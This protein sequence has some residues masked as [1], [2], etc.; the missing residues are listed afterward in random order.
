[1]EFY[2]LN[3]VKPIL[4]YTR[5]PC[6]KQLLVV[7]VVLGSSDNYANG[8]TAWTIYLSEIPKTKHKKQ[9][10][11]KTIVSRKKKYFVVFTNIASLNFKF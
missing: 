7:E 5:D 3:A 4:Y 11:S 10:S 1:M 2:L 6:H 8:T 9:N